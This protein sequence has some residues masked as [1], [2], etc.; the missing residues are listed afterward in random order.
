MMGRKSTGG[1]LTKG[2]KSGKIKISRA[3]YEKV[4]KKINNQFYFYAE[5]KQGVIRSAELNALYRFDI[6][7]FD[8][9]IITDKEPLE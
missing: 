6:I 7:G 5:K 2:G 3:E 8:N 9:Y 4:R 1:G